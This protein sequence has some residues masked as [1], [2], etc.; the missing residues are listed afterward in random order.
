MPLNL[1][2]VLAYAYK[3]LWENRQDFLAY[4]FLPVVLVAGVK[5]LTLWVTGEWQIIFAPAPA[6]EA[7]VAAQ[8]LQ[9]TAADLVNLVVTLATYVMFAV[10]WHR[11]FL[12]GNEGNTVGGRAA[13]GRTTMEVP[14]LLRAL[15]VDRDPGFNLALTPDPH[16]GIRQRVQYILCD[17]CCADPCRLAVWAPA[18][19]LPGSSHRPADEPER[20]H[21]ANQGPQLA[22][23]RHRRDANPARHGG[24]AAGLDPAQQPVRSTFRSLGF[25]AAGHD[26]DP[27]GDHLRRNSRRC[28]GV[29]HRTPGTCGHPPGGNDLTDQQLYSQP[30]G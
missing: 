29:V 24:P 5:T 15:A 6:A 14:G 25:A 9:L 8:I 3:F 19:G 2:T 1:A 12:I 20:I 16:A 22:D 7:E 28:D 27:A 10:A 26:P 30:D 23:A 21:S 18:A 4:A 13:L 17:P 11:K